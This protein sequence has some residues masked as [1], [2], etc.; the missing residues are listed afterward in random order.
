MKFLSQWD[1][2][3]RMPVALLS[4]YLGSGKTTLVNALLR[5]PRMTNT[6]VAVNEFGEVPIDGDLIE[7]GADRTV[8]MANGCLCCNLVGDLDQAVMRLFAQRGDGTLPTFERLIIEPSGLSDAAPIAQAILRNPVLSRVLRLE[9]IV[10][11]VDALFAPAQLARHPQTRKQIALADHLVVTKTDLVTDAALDDLR[12]ALRPFNPV[13]TIHIAQMGN[14]DPGLLFPPQFFDPVR[15]AP[16]YRAPLTADN[17]ADDHLGEVASVSLRA[18][19]PLRWRAFDAWLR[20]IRVNHA[21]RL[22]RVKGILN[23]IGETGPVVVQGV[24]HVVNAP[25]VLDAWPGLNHDTRLVLIADRA[26]VEAASASWAQAM[27]S[28]VAGPQN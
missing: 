25:V 12:V 16:A 14:V 27:P 4:G 9:V 3:S 23:I 13:A 7:H 22:L 19:Q 17:G 18:N 26:T 5:D 28:L 24:H 1:D 20:A 8:V 11:T 15:D 6:A 2:R 10:T 21:E